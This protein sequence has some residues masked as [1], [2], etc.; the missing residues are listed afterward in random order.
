MGQGPWGR[1]LSRGQGTGPRGEGGATPGESPEQ[2]TRHKQETLRGA[3]HKGRM[4]GSYLEKGEAPRGESQIELQEL[5]LTGSR[6]AEESLEQE[7]YP[8]EY[9]E[10]PK[11]YFE[12]LRGQ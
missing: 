9:R 12:R 7:R 1:R 5:I 4:V 10:L 6:Y 8:A 2:D 3:M 11:R